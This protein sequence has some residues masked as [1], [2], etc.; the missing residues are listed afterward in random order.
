[1][2]DYEIRDWRIKLSLRGHKKILRL[3][4]YLIVLIGAV[5]IVSNIGGAF[6]Y[7]FFY[8][9]LLYIPISIFYILYSIHSIRISQDMDGRVFRKGTLREYSLLIENAGLLP[10]GPITLIAADRVTDFKECI[11][12]TTYSLF[13]K[14]TIRL[15]NVISCKYSGSYEAGVVAFTIH[16]PFRIID[17]SYRISTPLRVNVLPAVTDIAVSDINRKLENI[18]IR[19]GNMVINNN[20]NYLGNDFRKYNPGDP[21]NRVHW[22]N[23]ARTGKLFIRLPEL[24]MSQMISLI[25]VKD[26]M[27]GSEESLKKRDYFLEYIVSVM[28]YFAKNKK[29]L[30][31]TYFD[32]GIRSCIVDDYES[33]DKAYFDVIKR[34]MSKPA[35]AEEEGMAEVKNKTSA[36]VIVFNEKELNLCQS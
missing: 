28:N 3:V 36:S 6:S 32:S 1:M 26:E 5:V 34:I 4:A 17:A 20:E 14:D 2:N 35:S 27:D 18:L 21:I 22:K 10:V 33:F 23:Y 8:S 9:V 7:V 19:S 29:P 12:D 15:E 25:I 11:T 31:I 13:P 16:D 30:E 24:K